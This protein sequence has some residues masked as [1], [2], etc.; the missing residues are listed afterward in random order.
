VHFH[1]ANRKDDHNDKCYFVLLSLNVMGNGVSKLFY[2]DKSRISV[3]K[4]IS[5]TNISQFKHEI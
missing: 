2:A 1:I 5:I 4:T 3:I